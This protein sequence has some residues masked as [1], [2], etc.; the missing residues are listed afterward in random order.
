MRLEGHLESLSIRR[1]HNCTRGQF[2]ARRGD[3]IG[4]EVK[5]RITTSRTYSLSLWAKKLKPARCDRVASS[6]ASRYRCFSASLSD[7]YCRANSAMLCFVNRSPPLISCTKAR[8]APPARRSVG[9]FCFLTGFLS[10]CFLRLIFSANKARRD[11]K[12]WKVRPMNLAVKV[13][14]LGHHPLLLKR[15]ISLLEACR[16]SKAA[17]SVDIIDARAYS[18]AVAS[19]DSSFLAVSLSECEAW[20]R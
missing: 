9:F 8:Q 18:T 10:A 17:M 11:L 12:A 19:L 16:A 4:Q 6:P 2:I 7:P 14:R 5:L 1:C 15:L 13:C 20:P 3:L